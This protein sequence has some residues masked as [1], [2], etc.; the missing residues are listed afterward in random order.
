MSKFFRKNT[1]KLSSQNILPKNENE[2][3][4]LTTHFFETFFQNFSS[5]FKNGQKKCP[6]SKTQNTF[7]KKVVTS[8][9]P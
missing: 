2:S 5:L 9:M 3:I 1:K 6:K 7:W 4:M 8:K